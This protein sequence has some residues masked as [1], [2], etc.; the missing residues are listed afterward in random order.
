MDPVKFEIL[1][2]DKTKEGTASAENNVDALTAKVNQQKSVISSLTKEV[3]KLEASMLK[4]T[5]KGELISGE[6]IAYVENLK[7]KV[8]DLKAELVL[9]EQEKKKVANTPMVAPQTTAGIEGVQKSMKMLQ[10]NTQQVARELPSLALSPQ[11]FILAIS[12]N[13]PML[14]DSYKRARA[15][16][17]A[18]SVEQR[19][20]AIPAWR[21]FVGAIF[22]VQTAVIVGITLFIAYGK[23]IGKWT[24]NL[25]KS[26]EA[27]DANVR[28]MN[29]LGEARLKGEK[30]AQSELTRLKLLYQGLKEENVSRSDKLRIVKELQNKYP[31][32]FGNLN[33]E[34]ILAGKAEKAYLKL[35]KAIMDTAKA[36]AIQDKIVDNEKKSLELRGKLATEIAKLEAT[37]Q[38]ELRSYG[39]RQWTA[40][41]G[42]YKTQKKVV[43]DIIEQRDLLK[44]SNAALAK[45]INNPSDLLDVDK[46]SPI[47]PDT[48]NL[49]DKIADARVQ[50][51]K[52]ASEM[53]LNAMKDGYEKKKAQLKKQFQ[54]ETA[55]IEK[56]AR[57]RLQALEKAKKSGL[58]VT[59][60]QI[61]S[62]GIMENRQKELAQAAYMN[63]LALLFESQMDGLS[64][65][66]NDYTLKRL[67][68][69][70]NYNEEVKRLIQ[71]RTEAEK[72]G[73]LVAVQ[74]L[75]IA[76]SEA[77]VNK[78]K[79]L[80]KASFDQFKE[81][82]EYI[83]A[84]EDLKN[85]STETLTYLMNQM[86]KYKSVA[87]EA[88][89]PES[90]REYM[91][92]LREISDELAERNP[93]QMLIEKRKEL[94]QAEKEM[95]AAQF[96][97]DAIRSGSP[98]ISGISMKGGKVTPIYLTEDEALKKLNNSKDK[99]NRISNKT[100]KIEKKVNEQVT[101]LYDTLNSL[102]NT[103]GGT[104]GQIISLMSEFGLFT[105]NLITGIKDL[106]KT[107]VEELTTLEKSSIILTL[108]STGIQLLQKLEQI[109]PDAYDKY[110]K[111][112][113]KIEEINRLKDAVLEYEFAVLKAKQAEKGWFG[114]DNLQS[115]KDYKEQQKQIM[116]QYIAKALEQQAI[117]QNQSGGGWITNP[118]N[119]LLGVYDSIYGTS[120]F[121]HDYE[122]GTT[123]AIN[124]L[125]IETRKRSKG[126]MG[127]GVGG[128][129]QKTEDLTTWARNNG[130]GELF[131]ND[132]VNG[133]PLVDLSVAQ[134]LLDKYGNKLVG[135]TKETLEELVA[136]RKRYDEFV[137]QL[138]EYVNQMYSPLVDN[139]IDSLWDWFDEGKDAMDS[140]K[141]YAKSTF[142]EI[143]S[144]MLKTIALKKVFGSFEDDIAKI[145]E[146]FS[147]DD[148]DMAS[149]S[150]QIAARVQQLA[151]DYQT[152]MP[153]LQ[154]ILRLITDAF[155]GQGF[156]LKDISKGSQTANATITSQVTEDTMTWLAG[157]MVAQ[158][159]RLISVDNNIS[160]LRTQVDRALAPLTLIAA[161]TK[162]TADRLAVI[163]SDILIMRR[164]GV[165]IKN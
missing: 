111:Y 1:A 147:G 49:L 44:K 142:R 160:G 124:N 43:D 120:I 141:D 105:G 117:Y 70:K 107:G 99:Y 156:N 122:K 56:D 132:K 89:S 162:A 3:N 114:D 65:K 24:S 4:K 29:D 94:A 27:I 22:S 77:T 106:A 63:Q 21:Q 79:E 35:A 103:I 161:N 54:D 137:A 95:T 14:I 71:L 57:E 26:K 163:A 30:S 164:D 87:A 91:T 7:V 83:R 109:T 157:S 25:F 19:K 98:V 134:T 37:P 150:Q 61:D 48:Q 165:N 135:Q 138:Q 51:E 53:E 133:V 5:A 92:T 74:Q 41:S 81:S 151:E 112:D 58:P 158:T 149:F 47:G 2:V 15:E 72:K 10:Y 154:E 128:H 12:N 152:Q 159:N 36:R 143:I 97:Y 116:D 67:A 66:Y 46:K 20:N 136:L 118:W 131:S 31:S 16:I 23:E 42:Q 8:Q 144:D 13:I 60:D 145:Y 45:E 110:L 125:R 88:W 33:A 121:G 93:F 123:A 129:S 6:D 148:S 115:L 102:G 34:Q 55:E 50:A 68:I 28:A 62:V 11:M 100:I 76:L 64:A 146:Q 39:G 86:E 90:L 126:F 101:N 32:Y 153:F 85:T 127:S 9:L 130:L 75:D 40:E 119:S 108:I 80:M 96:A 17:A 113:E 73:N 69:E 78:G 139:M 140:F 18:M 104:Q 84:F 52:K 82:P 59:R 155:A 38:T